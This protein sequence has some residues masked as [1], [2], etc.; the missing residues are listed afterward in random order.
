MT[1][2]DVASGKGLKKREKSYWKLL[3]VETE[4]LPALLPYKEDR[5]RT[6]CMGWSSKGDGPSRV[7]KSD[8]FLL[9]L[10]KS[11]TREMS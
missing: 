4:I 10:V 1:V 7:L 8:F 3:L 2:F 9:L 6:L 5:K 11:E